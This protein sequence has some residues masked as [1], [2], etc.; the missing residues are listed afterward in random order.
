MIQKC[1]TKPASA[2]FYVLIFTHPYIVDFE[3]ALGR[4]EVLTEARGCGGIQ[5]QVWD[6]TPQDRILAV[7]ISKAVLS[8]HLLTSPAPQFSPM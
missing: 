3:T 4:K 8:G 5:S 2:H 7:S 6:Q 1:F